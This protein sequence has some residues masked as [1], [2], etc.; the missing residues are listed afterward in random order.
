MNPLSISWQNNIYVAYLKDEIESLCFHK[1]VQ[2]SY[3]G[4]CNMYRNDLVKSFAYL[5]IKYGFIAKNSVDIP[6]NTHL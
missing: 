6:V 2:S 3:D 4:G 1:N 5:F